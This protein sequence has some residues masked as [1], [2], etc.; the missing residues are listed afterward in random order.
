MAWCLIKSEQEAFKKALVEKKLNPFALA[1]MT[2][3]QRRAE[4]EKYV[5]TENADNI[6]SLY[7]SKLLLKNQV[8]GT[9][10]WDKRPAGLKATVKRYLITK[11]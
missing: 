8:T 4:F 5:G 7:E 10:H 1:E 2:S 6:N 9:N 11:I 3:E